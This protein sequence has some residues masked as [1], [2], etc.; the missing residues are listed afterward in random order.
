MIEDLWSKRGQTFTLAK[1]SGV[2]LGVLSTLLYNF[3]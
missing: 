2:F 1:S 3:L